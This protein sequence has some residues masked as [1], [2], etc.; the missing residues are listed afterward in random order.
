VVPR[1]GLSAHA[2]NLNKI[3]YFE[4]ISVRGVYH[5]CAP[6]S[7]VFITD[8]HSAIKALATHDRLRQVHHYQNEKIFIAALDPWRLLHCR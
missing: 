1:K 4:A 6:K 8:S 2:N 7:I 5:R 3:R